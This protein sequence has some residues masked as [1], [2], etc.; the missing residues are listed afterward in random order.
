[1]TILDYAYREVSVSS[2]AGGGSGTHD[3]FSAG[4]IAKAMIDFCTDPACGLSQVKFNSSYDFAVTVDRQP[5]GPDMP[6]TTVSAVK[7]TTGTEVF[8][9]TQFQR[10]IPGD[11]MAVTA[12]ANTAILPLG[13]YKVQRV[14]IDYN[15]NPNPNWFTLLA[16]L[17]QPGSTQ[18]FNATVTDAV[19][20]K[21][22]AIK[23]G[24]VTHIFSAPEDETIFT[25]Q[26]DKLSLSHLSLDSPYSPGSSR[27]NA[28]IYPSETVGRASPSTPA[29][30][31]TD[32]VG[33][34]L[35]RLS[36]LHCF[37]CEGAF[38]FFIEKTDGSY[39]SFSFGD[40]KQRGNWIGKEFASMQ[41]FHPRFMHKPAPGITHASMFNGMCV[42]LNRA[43]GDPYTRNDYIIQY[44]TGAECFRWMTT[45]FRCYY[46]ASRSGAKETVSSP[47]NAHW[48]MA[49]AF[50]QG[51]LA[52]MTKQATEW[53]AAV[54]AGTPEQ[55]PALAGYV[56]AVITGF[57]GVIGN[58]DYTTYGATLG[59]RNQ[60]YQTNIGGGDVP[61]AKNIM[62]YGSGSTEIPYANT[63]T[64]RDD[65]MRRCAVQHGLVAIGGLNVASP[66]GWNN[67]I[68]GFEFEVFVKEYRLDEEALVARYL[69]AGVMPGIRAANVYGFAA[70]D[71]VNS[72]WMVF[73]V[74]KISK[75][76]EYD[77][78][79]FPSCYGLGYLVKKGVTI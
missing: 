55:N 46:P 20:R 2:I 59:F 43:Y 3:N 73:P 13:A 34:Y 70:K 40:M 49:G 4:S 74:T 64:G 44:P 69:D 54:G 75:T 77:A 18:F 65:A 11:Y 7:L 9:P 5:V 25:T 28:T 16:T 78:A 10:Q 66:N 27:V 56:P 63:E 19:K 21:V 29:V 12:S 48:A 14:E 57:Q 1:M 23:N 71:I 62:P 8:F 31:P 32:S 45:K 26:P 67:R 24:A 38:Y 61:G 17:P 53:F 50:G 76:Q 30:V 22:W 42:G 39:T 79:S 33:N 68:A 37:K 47:P 72:D 6:P 35:T 15:G 51:V 60:D 41:W 52:G 58:I 36:K